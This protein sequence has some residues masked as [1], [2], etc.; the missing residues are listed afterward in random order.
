MATLKELRSL[1]NDSD[2]QEQVEAAIIIAAHNKRAG[3]PTAAEKAWAAYVFES[4][5]A[6]AKKA[7]MGVIAE[8]SALTVEQI[9]QASPTAIQNSVDGIAD[10]LVDA[11][12]GA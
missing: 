7:L 6:E 5:A 11:M 8:H 10:L 9:K 2:L 4:P 3:S 1:F 12:S